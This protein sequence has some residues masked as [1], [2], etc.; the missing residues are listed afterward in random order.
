MKPS[1][2]SRRAVRAAPVKK[3]FRVSWTVAAI[4]CVLGAALLG[5]SIFRMTRKPDATQQQPA[6]DK[7]L[8]RLQAQ[9]DTAEAEL[10]AAKEKNKPA[11]TEYE[12]L[13]AD[14]KEMAERTKAREAKIK[15][16]EAFNRKRITDAQ[17]KLESVKNREE[18]DTASA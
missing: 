10:A 15:E 14:N 7:E 17:R 3:P 6:G 12:T 16:H 9:L 4:L 11:R 18:Q 5:F 2:S 8:Q 13:V 1:Q